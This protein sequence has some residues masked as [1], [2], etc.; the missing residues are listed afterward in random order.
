MWLLQI[1]M[2]I[3]TES[4]GHSNRYHSESSP[5]TISPMPQS[6]SSCKKFAKVKKKNVLI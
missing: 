4:A 6:S 2:L 3:S 1:K 5:R